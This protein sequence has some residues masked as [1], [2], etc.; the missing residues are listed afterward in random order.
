MI[1]STL[2]ASGGVNLA[3]MGISWEGERLLV[4]PYRESATFRNLTLNGQ[5]VANFTDNVLVFARCAVGEA[6]FPTFQAERVRG[7]VLADA[8]HWREFEVE[9]ADRGAERARF[10][11]RVVHRGRVRDFAG[12]NR[13]KHAVIEAAVAASRIPWL[14]AA[15]VARQI[16][17]LAPLVE[18]T[19]G[20]EEREAYAFLL[21]HVRRAPAGSPPPGAKGEKK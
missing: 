9:T 11:C 20:P 8:C 14:G 10:L 19:A 16:E 1:V 13:A 15:E 7:A 2:D 21:D 17:A 6:P 5:G 4:R 18:K 12:L 3:P